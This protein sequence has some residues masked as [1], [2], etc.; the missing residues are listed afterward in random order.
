MQTLL[1]P[2][3]PGD[4][5]DDHRWFDVVWTTDEKTNDCQIFEVLPPFI[6]IAEACQRFPELMDD[7]PF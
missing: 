7:P 4:P 6:S 1:S 3:S 2:A 5:R